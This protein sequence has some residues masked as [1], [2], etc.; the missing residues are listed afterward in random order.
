MRPTMIAGFGWRAPMADTHEA[1][2]GLRR[3][4]ELLAEAMSL[5]AQAGIDEFSEVYF[6][7][8]GRHDVKD[9]GVLVLAGSRL[10]LLPADG[11]VSIPDVLAEDDKAG[12][13]ALLMAELC[14]VMVLWGL[15][16]PEVCRHLR[17]AP[18]ML[19]RWLEECTGADVP[20]LPTPV[21]NRIRRLL[22]VEQMR[23][24]IGIPDG[25][26]D[27]WVRK[28]QVAFRGE[29]VLD[30]IGAGDDVGYRRVLLW[31]LN[32]LRSVPTIHCGKTA[33]R[34][35]AKPVV[36]TVASKGYW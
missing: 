10:N 16:G 1:V 19:D 24:L 8:A 32:G 3:L 4:D 33:F 6:Y 14:F 34:H 15:E 27:G 25:T 2:T 17:C 22:A 28:P 23:I 20:V 30:L 9:A 18:S 26:V 12:R 31:M 11:D 35:E 36:K 5:L 13:R 21:M 7:V 29:S